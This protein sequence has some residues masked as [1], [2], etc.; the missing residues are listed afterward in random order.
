MEL[1]RFIFSEVHRAQQWV[2]ACARSLNIARVDASIILANLCGFPSWDHMV[3]RIGIEQPS[4][5]DEAIEE[6]QRKSRK[7]RYIKLLTTG[8]A[9]DKKSG[10]LLIENLS[11]SSSKPFQVFTLD[12][13]ELKVSHEKSNPESGDR[14][15]SDDETIDFGRLV[16]Q[17]LEDSPGGGLSNFLNSARL[18]GDTQPDRWFNI[19]TFLGWK[20]PEETFDADADLGEPAMIAMDDELGE[21]P[22]YLCSTVRSPSDEDDEAADLAMTMCMNDY[23]YGDYGGTALLIWRGPAYKKIRKKLYCHIGM[24]A[25]DEEWIEIL[26][27][28]DCT[29]PAITFKRNCELET[30]N[31]GH[32]ELIDEDN[33]LFDQIVHHLA[34]VGDPETPTNNWH[35]IKSKTP[36]G[37]TH[38]IMMPAD[39]DEE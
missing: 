26:V 28:R 12:V 16:A 35:A 38:M 30:I 4:P 22:I 17:L 36:T 20:I 1:E 24:I 13:P 2:E 3:Q 39:P 31:T 5:C 10:S 15:E 34:G 25:W 37:W 8:F 9:L 33:F 18:S 6:K 14:D 19:L 11:P 32:P 27:N 7:S 23:L 21:V 29:S